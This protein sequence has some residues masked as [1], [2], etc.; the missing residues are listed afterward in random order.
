MKAKKKMKIAGVFA[1][2][3]CPEGANAGYFCT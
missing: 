3:S 2:E 1:E